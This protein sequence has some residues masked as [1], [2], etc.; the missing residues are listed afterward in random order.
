MQNSFLRYAL[1]WFVAAGFLFLT[2]VVLYVFDQGRSEEGL[3]EAVQGNIQADFEACLAAAQ[4]PELPRPDACHLCDLRYSAS[5]R[6]SHWSNSTYLP[7]QDYIERIERISADRVITLQNR[8][9]YQIRIRKQGITRV[10]LIPVYISYEVENE[11]LRPFIFMGRW[12]SVLSDEEQAY[13][14]NVEVQPGETGNGE[15]GVQILDADGRPVLYLS[16]LPALPFRL[17]LR[18]G[19]IISFLLS[20]VTFLVALRLYVIQHR[21]QRYEV[22]LLLLGVTL[23][24]RGLLYAIDFPGN[25]LDAQLFSPSIL[26]FH[27]LAPS[28][29]ELTINII[30][31]TVVI[32]VV[33]THLLRISVLW[34]RRLLRHRTWSWVAMGTNLVLSS[35]LLK[36]YIDVFEVITLNSKV[37]IEFSNIF[38]TNLFSYLILLDVGML[39]LALLLVI[40]LLLRFNVIYWQQK[41]G[42]WPLGLMHLGLLGLTNSLLHPSAWAASLV[43]VFTLLTCLVVIH[44]GPNRHILKQNLVSY[45]LLTFVISLLVTYNVV[46]GVRINLQYKAV[47]IA[48]RV[49]SNQSTTAVL[50][51][52]KASRRIQTDISEIQAKMEMASDT[53]DFLDW[54]TENYLETNF[55]GFDIQAFLYDTTGAPL[56]PRLP[57]SEYGPGPGN[58]LPL[59]NRRESIK[60]SAQYPL[61]QLPHPSGMYADFF[62]GSFSFFLGSGETLPVEL[63]VE[64]R[65]INREVDGL[66]PS[67]SMEQSVFDDIQLISSM[68]HAVYRNGVLYTKRGQGGFPVSMEDYEQ[69]QGKTNRIRGDF[70]EYLEPFDGER[71]V[72]VRYPRQQVLEVITTF[73][74][75]FYFFN[76]ASLVLITLPLMLLRLM[77]QRKVSTSLPLRTK[78]RLGLITISVL[79]MLVIIVLLYPF[80][81]QRY[82]EDAQEELSLETRRITSLIEADYSLMNKDRFG[83]QSAIRGFRDKI[84]K[85]ASYISDDINVYDQFGTRLASTQPFISEAGI[86]TDLMNEVA[87]DSLRQGGLSELVLKERIGEL[88][89]LSAY[90]PLLDG[91]GRPIGFVNVPYLAQQDR[92]EKQVIDFLAYL[93][94]IYLL[95]FL[96]IN[97]LAVFISSTIT[98]P[99]T[100]I[101]QRLSATMLGNQNE[102]IHYRSRDEIGEIVNAYNK[103]LEQLEESEEKLASTQREAAW[104]SMA[105]QVAHEIKNPLTPMRLNIQ[106]LLRAQKQNEPRFQKMFPKVMNSLLVQIDSL[107]RIANSFHEFAKM[108]EPVNSTLRVNDVLLEVV[109]LYTQSEEAIWLVDIPEE[110]FWTQA[111]RDQL[112]RC[113]NNIIKN[114]LQAL[115]ENGIIQISMRILESKARVEIKDN[116]LGIPPEVQKRVFEP[117]FSTKNSGMG[118]GLAIVKRV[119]ENAGGEISFRSQVGVGTTFFIDLPRA[120]AP[121]HPHTR[122][123]SEE[124]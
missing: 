110:A 10:L 55:K 68:N 87:L 5:G 96:L 121:A 1:P 75:I 36:L 70:H 79:P 20:L 28:L 63:L 15:K 13:L 6:L 52:A 49:K 39:L 60:L 100:L 89:Y 81:S 105:R 2:S 109:D 33:Y 17:P 102:R 115:E 78:I 72:V 86:S 47:Q 14:R 53:E 104:R 69:I 93:A 92:L 30:T 25:Y 71:L 124:E 22:N 122:D 40:F 38:E 97:V 83:R 119:L 58:A 31:F 113:F 120:E 56:N 84:Q 67:L 90:R 44:R 11:F 65:P 118:L 106:H 16:Q 24:V 95:V 51:Y 29:G 88:E 112:S 99:L 74:I 46:V 62:V 123:V 35:V 21:E 27:F 85:M 76:L 98:Q 59:Q 116:G 37:D 48:E 50:N 80:V 64:L 91:L 54:L 114:A 3:L 108:P 18:Y 42:K 23:A 34:Y 73:S 103:M 66:Y 12:S 111:D 8:T 117:S 61:F 41:G 45:L 7:P 107:V 26:A 101:Q 4:N 9:Y 57:R 94:N 19:A 77:R 43:V 32:Y 82:Y